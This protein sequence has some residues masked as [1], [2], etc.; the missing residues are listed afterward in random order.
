MVTVSV[1][2]QMQSPGAAFPNP[3]LELAFSPEVTKTLSGEPAE[4]G[5]NTGLC[6]GTSSQQADCAKSFGL[7]QMAF[8]SLLFPPAPLCGK[9]AFP[10]GGFWPAS[11]DTPLTISPFLA[12]FS[13]ALHSSGKSQQR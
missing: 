1:C 2:L 11:L 8:S 5:A 3:A 13:A 6:E 9:L 12:T 4:H 7:K 10:V